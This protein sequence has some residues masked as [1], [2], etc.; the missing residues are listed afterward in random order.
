MGS[1]SCRKP[2]SRIA[3][4]WHMPKIKHSYSILKSK[5]LELYYYSKLCFFYNKWNLLTKHSLNTFCNGFYA[6]LSID[7]RKVW[8]NSRKQLICRLESISDGAGG[9]S[10]K[11]IEKW[12][13]RR[14]KTISQRLGVLDS[15][16]SGIG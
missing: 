14:N 16:S 9:I 2:S 6:V 15:S 13:G 10:V 11:F 4:R 12:M 3:I 1:T 7:N 5:P 8:M